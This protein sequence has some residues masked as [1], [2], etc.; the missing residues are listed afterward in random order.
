M[1]HLLLLSILRDF[2][3]EVKSQKL[4][5]FSLLKFLEPILGIE[6]PK[7]KTTILTLNYQ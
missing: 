7:F 4:W 2:G 6:L 5:D 3:M 1:L